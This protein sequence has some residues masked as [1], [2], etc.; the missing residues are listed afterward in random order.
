VKPPSTEE[1]LAG[2]RLPRH[3][4]P[5]AEPGE[6]GKSGGL[7]V[8]GPRCQDLADPMALGHEQGTSTLVRMK[9]APHPW[10]ELL[11]TRV[12]GDIRYLGSGKPAPGRFQLAA[13]RLGHKPHRTAGPSEIPG[14]HPCSPAGWLPQF[15]SV[16]R[17]GGQENYPAAAMPAFPT[18]ACL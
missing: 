15:M 5:M 6:M 16:G 10:L 14:W 8:T 17:R 1:L 11:E 3:L 13:L 7:R 9:S 2:E 12:Y 18:G 4:L